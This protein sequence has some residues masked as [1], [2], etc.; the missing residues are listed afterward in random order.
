MSNPGLYSGIYQQIREHAE[1]VDNVL[2]KLKTGEG[3]DNSLRLELADL[4][5]ELSVEKTD[6]LSTRMIA[7]LVI[8]DDATSRARWRRLSNNLK[9]EK[10]DVSAIHELENLAQLL[11]QVQA[12]AVAKMRGW[13]H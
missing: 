4:L 1:L 5:S 3:N 8:G 10:V 2:V 6:T 11:E 9:A 13:S 12:N 7:M